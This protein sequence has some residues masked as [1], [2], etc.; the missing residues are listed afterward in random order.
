MRE[1][2]ALKRG[3]TRWGERHD[4][5]GVQGERKQAVL[6]FGL[7]AIGLLIECYYATAPW[8]TS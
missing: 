5:G 3:G 6:P 8:H 4:E 7:N 1:S 2:D